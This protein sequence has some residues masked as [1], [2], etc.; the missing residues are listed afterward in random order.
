MDSFLKIP[1]VLHRRN[2]F[3]I[4]TNNAIFNDDNIFVELST[5]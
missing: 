5:L 4:R 3:I 1:F 2:K